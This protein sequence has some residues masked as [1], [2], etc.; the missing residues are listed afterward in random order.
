MYKPSHRYIHNIKNTLTYPYVYIHEHIS[1]I[2]MNKKNHRLLHMHK[3][4]D[5]QS[6]IDKSTSYTTQIGTY[7]S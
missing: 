4:N 7:M 2:Y 6:N 5:T 1:N 3:H